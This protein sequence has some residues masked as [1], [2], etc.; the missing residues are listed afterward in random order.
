MEETAMLTTSR[1]RQAVTITRSPLIKAIINRNAST[2]P[3]LKL[4]SE[5]RDRIFRLVVG[6]QLI[7]IKWIHHGGCSPAKLYYATCVA[8]VSE[9]EAYKE[10]SSGYNNIPSIDSPEYYT[11]TCEG[12]HEKCRLWDKY[13][14]TPMIKEKRQPRLLDLSMLGASR[15]MY[16]EANLLL[17]STNTFSFE[18]PVSF[19]KFMNKLTSLQKK[20]LTKMHIRIDWLSYDYEQ[21]ERVLK[22]RLLEKFKGLK[23]VHLCFDQDLVRLASFLYVYM[24]QKQDASSTGLLA[25]CHEIL[26]LDYPQLEPFGSLQMLRLQHATVVIAD[27]IGDVR[28][29]RSRW[30]IQK[31]REVA[32]KVRGKLLQPEGGR[33]LVAECKI[34]QEMREKGR[35]AMKAEEAVRRAE[36]AERKTLKEA[37]KA[38]REQRR[39][40]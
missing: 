26:F 24:L 12:R 11:S 23:T 34:K 14:K 37:Q 4:P 40:A 27:K 8:S 5:L 19:D 28:Q 17:W 38:A 7:H 3:L 21:W 18:D 33:A 31:K 25:S 35:E 6:D 30:S 20:K 16:E 10:F 13:G 22:I 36:R 32:E 9:H 29:S 39:M 2:S 15:Q 1:K